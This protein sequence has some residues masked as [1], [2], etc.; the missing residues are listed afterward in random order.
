MAAAPRS[1]PSGSPPSTEVGSAKVLE[2]AQVEA[3]PC[4]PSQEDGAERA[5]ANHGDLA[6]AAMLGDTAAVQRTLALASATQAELTS[7]LEAAAGAGQEQVVRLLCQ[8]AM[9]ESETGPATCTAAAAAAGVAGHMHVLNALLESDPEHGAHLLHV[10]A[11]AA[12]LAGN[13]AA[14]RDLTALLPSCRLEIE[15]GWT[16]AHYAAQGNHVTV[17]R[18]VWSLDSDRCEVPPLH[19]AAAAGAEDVVR[20]LLTHGVGPGAV[21]AAGRTALHWA[22]A[23]G[24]VG[25]MRCLLQGAAT[26]CVTPTDTRGLRPIDVAGSAAAQEWLL[27]RG[28]MA[29]L[30]R[31]GGGSALDPA[32]CL[33]PAPAQV[34]PKPATPL[35]PT[36][37]PEKRITAGAVHGGV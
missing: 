23:G 27:D 19:T 17:L 32:A 31:G 18:L 26:P 14:V 13:A 11:A 1:P 20:F 24:H 6:A 30:L 12:A 2:V 33:P 15:G 37:S 3:L 5:V 35:P 29:P 10:A 36:A 22:A 9:G 8:A 28:S 4:P 7:A 34:R 25:V 21:D 16:L